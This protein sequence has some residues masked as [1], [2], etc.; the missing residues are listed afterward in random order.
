MYVWTVPLNVKYF[1]AQRKALMWWTNGNT[2]ICGVCLKPIRTD[3]VQTH[4]LYRRGNAPRGSLDI[5]ENLIP[6]HAVCHA[7]AHGDLGGRAFQN[8]YKRLGHGDARG[9]YNRMRTALKEAI[10]TEPDIPA[11]EEDYENF[12]W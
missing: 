4:H 9:G 6:T 8:Q 11:P 3:R 7:R 1:K 2:L 10:S 5:P 12:D